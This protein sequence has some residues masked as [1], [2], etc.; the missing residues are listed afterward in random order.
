M[1]RTHA[2]WTRTKLLEHS[3]GVYEIFEAVVISYIRILLAISLKTHFQGV[4]VNSTTASR[5]ESTYEALDPISSPEPSKG[6]VAEGKR[7]GNNR[8][9]G[10]DWSGMTEKEARAPREGKGRSRSA[11]QLERSPWA[12]SAVRSGIGIIYNSRGKLSRV[13]AVAKSR[14]RRSLPFLPAVDHRIRSMNFYLL[15]RKASLQIHLHSP[16]FLLRQP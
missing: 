8:E 13:R 6:N 14:D 2:H 15:D 7:S 9:R 10:N 11:K 3:R 12:S 1:R 4:F 16:T 5:F